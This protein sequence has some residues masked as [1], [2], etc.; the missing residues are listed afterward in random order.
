MQ[1]TRPSSRA[2]WAVACQEVFTHASAFLGSYNTAGTVRE[3][4]MI[5]DSS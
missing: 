2:R 3:L 4:K 1:K 5:G